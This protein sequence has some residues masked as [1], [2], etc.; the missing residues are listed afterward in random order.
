MS[1]VNQGVFQFLKE[2]TFR[3]ILAFLQLNAKPSITYQYLKGHQI[4]DRMICPYSA[5]V[6]CLT[7]GMDLGRTWTE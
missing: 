7:N 1:L 6:L 4:S 3:G 5:S 2:V